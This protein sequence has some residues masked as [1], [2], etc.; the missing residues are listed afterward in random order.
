MVLIYRKPIKE[1][2]HFSLD[3]C[4]F[5][6]PF[7]KIKVVSE[8]DWLTDNTRVVQEVSRMIMEGLAK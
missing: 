8:E 4:G 2:P 1:Q 5:L 6:L 3:W 7:D